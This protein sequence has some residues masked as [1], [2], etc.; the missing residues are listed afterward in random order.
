M[1]GVF[2]SH[3]S[4]DKPFVR[5]LAS[6][7]LAEGI[8]VWLDSWELEVGDPLVSRIEKGIG[9]SSLFVVVVSRKSIESGWVE[10]ELRTAMTRESQIGR[11]FVLP[12]KIDDCP[13][14]AFMNERV[15][16]DFK[17]GFS[18]AFS[19]L[20]SA[21]EK[22]GARALIPN[23]SEEIICLSFTKETNL[24]RSR[25]LKN[26]ES[27]RK[28]HPAAKIDPEQVK[29]IDDQEYI[30]LKL[31]LHAR[32]DRLHEEKWWSPDFELELKRIPEQ[33]RAEE[34]IL[35]EGVASIINSS[36]GAFHLRESL[37]WFSKFTRSRLC[38]S[39]YRSQNPDFDLIHYGKDCGAVWGLYSK[40]GI[41]R[42]YGTEGVFQVDA[43]STKYHPSYESVYIGLEQLR[44]SEY[45]ERGSIPFAS[46][47]EDYC[48]NDAF[49][50]YILPQ[51]LYWSISRNDHKEI[52]RQEDV[53]IGPH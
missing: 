36:A 34:K 19:V 15:Y 49:F 43:W 23:A 35:A 48:L 2:I 41:A 30:N 29:V 26:V 39:L 14:P 44:D 28:R 18:H 10:R 20:V 42:F 37:H 47:L 13:T 33:I 4:H 27:F 46:G 53:I 31:R 5:N 16:A 45:R 52:W 50:K 21:L 25:L 7:L 11:Q 8:P 17:H 51:A 9:D 38:Y 3:S 40:D 1:A 24:D 32:I 22:R 12:I 6:S